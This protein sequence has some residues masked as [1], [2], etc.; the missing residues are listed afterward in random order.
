MIVSWFGGRGP[1]RDIETDADR[2][3]SALGDYAYDLARTRA[4]EAREAQE[5]WNAVRRE[6]GRRTGR[7]FLDAATRMLKR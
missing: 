5:H 4:I 6:I 2:L 3:Q 7:S 1:R